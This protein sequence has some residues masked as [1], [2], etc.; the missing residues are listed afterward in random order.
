[1]GDEDDD[2]NGNGN[3]TR[4]LG[5]S[6]GDY[7]N[8]YGGESS[9]GYYDNDDN[10]VRMYGHTPSLADLGALTSVVR[11]YQAVAAAGDELPG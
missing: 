2:D 9:N 1:M 7:D 11:H 6:D 5:D 8:D 10:V 3:N 4:R